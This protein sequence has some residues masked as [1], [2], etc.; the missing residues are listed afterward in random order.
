MIRMNCLLC[1]KHGTKKKICVLKWTIKKIDPA[2]FQIHV[3][4]QNMDIFQNS[5]SVP[6]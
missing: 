5:T 3:Q 4:N 1:H 6:T 2:K